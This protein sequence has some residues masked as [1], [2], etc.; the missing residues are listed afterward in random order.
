MQKSLNQRRPI[1]RNDSLCENPSD[2]ARY[3]RIMIEA[4]ITTRW[5]AFV[6]TGTWHMDGS[7]MY[8]GKVS[9]HQT[10]N[11]FTKMTWT[12][13][14][15]SRNTSPPYWHGHPRIELEE[16]GVQGQNVTPVAPEATPTIL[17][18][19]FRRDWKSRHGMRIFSLVDSPCSWIRKFHTALASLQKDDI[20]SSVSDR[21]TLIHWHWCCHRHQHGQWH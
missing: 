9:P 21:S 7:T 11:G 8:T 1:T 15:S 20:C 12:H 2:P 3:S 17:R 5:N 19:G 6:I 10:M 18:V 4:V 13:P 14:I 16:G